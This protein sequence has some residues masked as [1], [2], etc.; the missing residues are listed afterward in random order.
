MSDKKFILH[1]ISPLK[2]VSPFDVNMAVD[3]GFD[4]VA[5][6]SDVD[7]KEVAGLVQDAIFSRAPEDGKRTAIL[8]GGRDPMLALDMLEAARN[9]MVPPWFEISVLADPSGAFTTAAGMIAVAEKRLQAAGR[10]LAGSRVAV[11]GATG[12]V[13]AIAGLI[14]AQAGAKV[15]LVGYDGLQR[16]TAR[17]EAFGERFGVALQPADGSDEAKKAA[18]VEG[19]E[20][21]LAAGRAGVQILSAAQLARAKDLKVA[22]DVNAVPPAGLEG[23]GAFDDGKQIDGTGGVGVGALAVGNVKFKTEHELLAAMRDPEKPSYSA[24]AEAFAVARRHAG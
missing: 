13:G 8:I 5:P 9:A 6:Y 10:E 3:A 7:L 11:F 22:L 16:V 4:V 12:P 18:V 19:A 2:N 14:A 21:I 1:F 24:F 15:T 23:V 20:V 17:A